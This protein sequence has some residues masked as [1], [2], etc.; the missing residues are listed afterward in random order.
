MLDM[1][2]ATQ[3]KSFFKLSTRTPI[4]LPDLFSKKGD[5][6]T[7]Q[8]QLPTL[9]HTSNSDDDPTSDSPRKGA[10]DA[11]ARELQEEARS[12]VMEQ[13]FG[14]DWDS[15]LAEAAELPSD[16]SRNAS[17]DDVSNIS[18]LEEVDG[19]ISEFQ[20]DPLVKDAFEK[21]IDLHHYSEDLNKDLERQENELVQEYIKASDGF[22]SLHGQIKSC[23][24]FLERMERMLSGFQTDLK[25]VS[26]EIQSLQD[27]ST[28]LN[29][30]LRNRHA[31]Q[32]R[33]GGVLDG[34]VIPPDLIRKVFEAEVN[35]LFLA[36]IVELNAKMAYVKANRDK[37]IKAFKDV[38][39]ELERLRNKAT[40]R[41]RDFFLEK[42]KT[43]RLANT[44]VQIIQTSVLIKY[45][46]LNQ[47]VMTWHP[48]IA[49]EIRQNYILIIS[50]YYLSLFERYVKSVQRLQLP[51]P[52]RGDMIGGE[53]NAKKSIFA[54]TKL[55]ARDKANVFTLG[56]RVDI[57]TDVDASVII[58]HV[59]EENNQKFPF[60]A[61]FRSLTRMVIDSATA[62]F[63][64]CTEFFYNT[65]RRLGNEQ[66]I[67]SAVFEQSFEATLKICL[68]M[69]MTFTANTLDAIGVLL[70]LR[71]NHLHEQMLKQRTITVL[72]AFLAQVNAILWPRFHA[73][74]E[75]HTDSVRKAVASKLLTSKETHPHHI[76]RRYAEFAVSLLSLNDNY[77]DPQVPG[78]LL[79]L[80][81]EVEALLGRMSAEFGDR[82]Q[83]LV[84]RINNYDLVLSVVQVDTFY[85][86]HWD[87]L[88]N[89]TILDYV[90]EVS[91]PYFGALMTFVTETEQEP[92]L[93]DVPADKFERVSDDFSNK[94]RQ[95][96]AT[97]NASVA[98]TFPNFK[99]GTAVLQAVLSQVAVFWSRYHVLLDKRFKKG[100]P[101]RSQPVGVQNVMVEMKKYRVDGQVLDENLVVGFSSSVANFSKT[102]LGEEIRELVSG[103][104]RVT[105]QE[106]GNYLFVIHSSLTESSVVVQAVLRDLTALLQLLFGNHERWDD[107]TLDLSGAQD[108]VSM[109]CTNGP[110]DPLIISGGQYQLLHDQ[111]TTERLDKL[112][113]LLETHEGVCANGTMLILG[114]SSSLH[115]RMN[116]NEARLMLLLN[117]ARPLLFN[118]VS[119]MPVFCN[120]SWFNLYRVRLQWHTLLVLTY[121]DKSFNS[122]EQRVE[123]FRIALSQSRL[124]IPTE[125]SP[126]LLRL[127]AKR[128]TL[129]MLYINRKTGLTLFP[130]P[131]PGP[132]T[133]VKDIIEAFWR[134]LYDACAA[135]QIPGVTEYSLTKDMFR[136]HA[137][138]DGVHTLYVLFSAQSISSEQLPS[139]AA[140][141]LRNITTR[142]ATPASACFA[143]LY[144][145]QKAK[146]AKTWHDGQLQFCAKTCRASLFDDKGMQLDKKFVQLGQLQAGS[147]LE[148]DRHFITIEG[149]GGA[150]AAA[151]ATATATATVQAQPDPAPA[152]RPLAANR[153][154]I[155]AS[156][157]L[158][159]PRAKFTSPLISAAPASTAVATTA[160]STASDQLPVALRE[161]PAAQQPEAAVVEYIALYSN[162]KA[163]KNKTWTDGT[164]TYSPDNRKAVLYDENKR[165]IDSLFLPT[166]PSV[167]D[168]LEFDRHLV[169][170]EQSPQGQSAPKLSLPSSTV[171]SARVVQ[172]A[173]F[174]VPSMRA[175]TAPAKRKQPPSPAANAVPRSPSEVLLQ[176]HAL[177]SEVEVATDAG[178]YT[179]S[180]GPP[181][182]LRRTAPPP[183][184]R[185]TFQPPSIA[186]KTLRFPSAG[187]CAPYQQTF[188][189]MQRTRHIPDTF[190]TMDAY[191]DTFLGAI[192]EHLQVMV[193]ELAVRYHAVAAGNKQ[194][195]DFETVCRR[196]GI[197]MHYPCSI[198]YA[199]QSK[200]RKRPIQMWFDNRLTYCKDDLWVISSDASFSSGT[201]F[202][203]RSTY[204]G[205]SNNR[206]LEL[207]PVQ[208][209]DGTAVERVLGESGSAEQCYALRLFDCSDFTQIDFIEEDLDTIPIID[210]L[211]NPSVAGAALLKHGRPRKAISSPGSDDAG[212][213]FADVPIREYM[214]MIERITG[215]YSLNEDQHMVLETWALSL[216]SPLNP[217]T[218]VHGVF[219]S[220]KSHLITILVIF[221]T[222][223]L[224]RLDVRSP[225][226]TK[227]RV[228]VSS[229]TNVAVDRILL[230]LLEK[231]FEEFVRVGSLRKI[232]KR[233]LPYTAQSRQTE[234]LKDLRAMLSDPSIGEEERIAVQ[235]AIA[236]FTDGDRQAIVNQTFVVGVTCLATSFEVLRD[237][238][239][240]L[241]ILDEC[242]QMTEPGSLLPLRFGCEHLLCVGDPLQLPPTIETSCTHDRHLDRTM[243]ERLASAGV[244]PIQLRTQYRCHPLISAIPN[245]LFYANA[246]RNGET[247][248]GAERAQQMLPGL[249]VVGFVDVQAGVESQVPGGSYVNHREVDA[250]AKMVEV[251]LAKGVPAEDIG[252]IT[253]YKGQAHAIAERI[254]PSP[255]SGGSGAEGSLAQTY[256]SSNVQVSTVDAFQGAEKCII[257]VSCVRTRSIGFSDDRR[258]INVLLTRAKHH[259]FIV[260]HGGLL[261]GNRLWNAILHEFCKPAE[262]GYTTFEVFMGLL[263]QVPRMGPAVRRVPTVTA[264]AFEI[265]DGE[266]DDEEEVMA[267][268]H[269]RPTR[270]TKTMAAT[271]VAK[272]TA[273]VALTPVAQRLMSQDLFEDSPPLRTPRMALQEMPA[274]EASEFENSPGPQAD[275]TAEPQPQSAAQ[276]DLEPREQGQEPA[277]KVEDIF[278]MD[279]DLEG[280]M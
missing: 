237:A 256:S 177:L 192:Y 222:R 32:T 182:T 221:V 79:K 224:E 56:T 245:A 255:S 36:T 250:V 229:N 43:L 141:I 68:Q 217:V 109:F 17:I 60:E 9:V 122:I 152:R 271:P 172:S 10:A 81:N 202:F 194:R 2:P 254:S 279:E 261:G 146:K 29:V 13:L 61:L 25:N 22:A 273:T 171:T 187:E 240:A 73:V 86:H 114:E 155:L 167:G 31:V 74:M 63:A 123:D 108:V 3:D 275:V 199:N 138:S 253:L 265:D 193:F 20:E 113:L 203:C 94:W 161:E 64:F 95:H 131:R 236:R 208:A 162:Q 210:Y 102:L 260:G 156:R 35:E 65:R 75:M 46:Y 215:E 264:Q 183:V 157:S 118:R 144:T 234:D 206:G 14:E 223:V 82:K 89:H 99:N 48:D 106:L 51:G 49:Q 218:L 228:L 105:Y 227:Y 196:R 154:S 42:F 239:F 207:A 93:Q 184:S 91:Q 180:V 246:L 28:L 70:C 197:G 200:D 76:M 230:G 27:Q 262:H 169:M 181:K 170:L 128:E 104:G 198:R 127:F 189:K 136:Y 19:K 143:V 159:A 179:S 225:V 149:V 174:R 107:D 124:E 129:A 160:A 280:L 204:H 7:Q 21:G 211:L 216:R 244:A 116:K 47:F 34:I 83:Q 251:L 191:R 59:A 173:P 133:Q 15:I 176:G 84:F 62:E 213:S 135:L 270:A 41:I 97:L 142:Y 201:T 188:K 219:G 58:A 212:P 258:R 263:R 44:N 71:V 272:E 134:L 243:F 195:A 278:A 226:D 168:E 220:G 119:F 18:A 78:D 140:E 267:H 238:K 241:V 26:G 8:P 186:P 269:R 249:P 23:D 158:T 232:A 80:R 112:L 38:G 164:L 121:I 52:E 247:T 130:Q 120:G 150:A 6:G 259:L 92:S 66:A 266:D 69:L 96:L 103:Q 57:L 12:K 37:H 5:G 190:A 126:I 163:K 98:Q 231:G 67:A 30:K 100:V 233:I 276:S 16:H 165:R 151:V 55:A 125:E 111:Q 90:D 252:V 185:S 277:E 40:E 137:R 39:P 115:S 139:T 53:E 87:K 117:R 242:S 72:D 54:S 4:V 1:Q 175:A 132:D 235:T 50:R 33:L 209:V 205:I 268:Y 45:K 178:V 24:A 77:N 11:T 85:R 274:Y 147:E 101:F 110:Q 145:S 148:F 257:V 88:F 166:Q 153:R 248:L 214:D